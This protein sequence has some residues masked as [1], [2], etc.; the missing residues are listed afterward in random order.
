MTTDWDPSRHYDTW[1]GPVEQPGESKRRDEGVADTTG[2]GS[3]T[4][5][6]CRPAGD[7]GSTPIGG[8]PSP[9]I[10]ADQAGPV[11]PQLV[12]SGT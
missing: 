10:T 7:R 8:S 3:P 12:P 5:S 6:N 4:V 2:E 1:R 11:D 9:P